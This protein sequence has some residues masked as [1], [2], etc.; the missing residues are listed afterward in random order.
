MKKRASDLG[1]KIRLIMID[2]EGALGDA[3]QAKRMQAVENHYKWVEAAMMNNKSEQ[4][5]DCAD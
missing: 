5:M 3:D 4:Q 1:V 2:G